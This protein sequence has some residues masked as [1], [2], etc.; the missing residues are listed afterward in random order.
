MNLIIA[1]TGPGAENPLIV[2]AFSRKSDKITA[3]APMK[4]DS[5]DKFIPYSLAVFA[6]S[7]LFSVTAVQGAM[8]LALLL[9]SLSRGSGALTELRDRIPAQP[10]FKPWMFF[11]GACLLAAIAAY[12][13][14]KGLHG[15]KS[16]FNRFLCFTILMLTIRR[17]H[18]PRLD[19]AFT[20]AAALA[21]IVGIYQAGYSII[22]GD[23]EIRR[24]SGFMNAIRYS[25]LMGIAL[26]LA[27]SRLLFW[28][29]DSPGKRALYGLTALACAAA[30]ILSQTRGA[31][32]GAVAAIVALLYFA[33]GR[34]V[35]VLAM[36]AVVLAIGTAG[37]AVTPGAKARLAA[38]IDR[39]PAELT[40]NTP[41]TAINIRLELWS[42]GLDMVKEH[43]VTGVGPDNIKRVFKKF[44]PGPIGYE[45]VWGSLHNLYLHQA[46]E[47]G[48]IGLAALL[49][50][51]G[52]MLRFAV[53]NLKSA[54]GPYTL[55]AA[56]VLPAYFVMN[57]TE[58]SFQHVH[59]SYAI[60]MA[61]AFSAAS[62]RAGDQG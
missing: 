30:L 44:H 47:R 53:K 14:L 21:A 18:L 48:L 13:P 26:T 33:K 1:K 19:S 3:L 51:F 12:Y 24:A 57:L 31:Y 45:D 46:A 27:A 22:S 58:N 4:T 38:M 34:R 40:T 17:E 8:L 52:A 50:L 20:A 54:F 28:E 16:D 42:L 35:R 60:L 25:E 7:L 23:A 10:L 56:A 49:T 55:W 29:N 39:N 9:W 62:V 59:T 2:L 41:S 37:I 61:L 5:A 6:F 43:P 15:F 36:S 32:L 11:L